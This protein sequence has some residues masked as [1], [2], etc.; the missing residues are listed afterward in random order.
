MFLSLFISFFSSFM[1]HLTALTFIFFF[2][3]MDL[4]SL[5]PWGPG[6]QWLR[7]AASLVVYAACY[8]Y[9]LL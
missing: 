8:L 7:T 2:Y 5:S 4:L 9:G 3:R 6:V 1:Y